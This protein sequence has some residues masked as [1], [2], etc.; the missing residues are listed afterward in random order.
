[1]DLIPEI[2]NSLQILMF[3]IFTDPG[4]WETLGCKLQV[5]QTFVPFPHRQVFV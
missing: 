4:S 2:S 3:S 5:G 1:M